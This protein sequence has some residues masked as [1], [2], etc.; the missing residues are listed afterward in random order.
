M[1]SKKLVVSRFSAAATG[2]ALLMLAAPEAGLAQQGGPRVEKVERHVQIV[3]TPGTPVGGAFG[4]V[5]AV[6]AGGHTVQFLSAGYRAMGDTVKGAPYSAESVNETVQT[7]ADGNRIR[8]SNTATI[9]RDSEGRTRHEQKFDA[10]GPWA[11]SGD[12]PQVVFIND[13][14][15]NVHYVLHPN[16]RTATKITAQVASAE[17]SGNVEISASATANAAGEVKEFRWVSK[18]VTEVHGAPPPPPPPPGSGAVFT[19]RLP[20]PAGPAGPDVMYFAGEAGETKTEQ[21]S[22][23]MIEGVEAVGTRTTM[24][25]PANSVGNELAIEVVSESWFSP[26]LKTLVMSTRKDPRFGETTFRLRNVRLG[27]PIASLF[28][29][30]ADYK[31]TDEPNVFLREG[32]GGKGPDVMMRRRMPAP[33][34][35]AK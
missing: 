6:P 20:A 2:A 1:F 12:A 28:E 35:Q 5:E 33:A 15:S 13:P 14:V 3:A 4:A 17:A 16:D 34:G 25:I 9:Y 24:T 19:R 29:V 27:E 10:I 32:P 21:L 11:T 30:P 18:D 23:R 26:E 8:R 22:K 31:I 7:L